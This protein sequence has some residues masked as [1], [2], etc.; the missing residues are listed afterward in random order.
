MFRGSKFE[1]FEKL[2]PVFK[3]DHRLGESKKDLNEMMNEGILDNIPTLTLKNKKEIDLV[4]SSNNFDTMATMN[5]LEF[6]D[7]PNL[8]LVCMQTIL[9]NCKTSR[10]GERFQS[11]HQT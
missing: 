10:H 6:P 1:K 7:D 4:R 11:D 3:V 9:E 8:A 2:A 5:L